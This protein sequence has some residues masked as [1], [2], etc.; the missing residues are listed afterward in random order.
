[1]KRPRYI[2]YKAKM[3]LVWR[4]QAKSS[5]VTESLAE[6]FTGLREAELGYHP[7]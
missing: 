4:R 5:L 7:L 1:M 6:G 3:C 2:G